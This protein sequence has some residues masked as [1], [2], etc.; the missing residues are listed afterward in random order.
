MNIII[1][2]NNLI[3]NAPNAFF[4]NSFPNFFRNSWIKNYWDK[5]RL[6]FY[7][8]QGKIVIT[9]SSFNPWEPPKYKTF[10]WINLDWRP[11]LKP[12]DIEGVI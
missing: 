7:F 3:G 1:K 5:T 11:A 6:M 10:S 8:I 12:Y 9:I 2:E 4:S